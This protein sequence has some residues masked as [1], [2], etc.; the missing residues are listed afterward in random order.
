MFKRVTATDKI[1]KLD[2]RIRAVAGG[3]GASKTISI[4]LVLIDMAQSDKKPTLTS[5]VSQSFPH[6]KRGAIRDF[7][8]ILQEHNY[9][10]DERW[11]KTDFVYTFETGSKI[12]FF[13]ADQSDKVR[14]PRRDRLFINEANNVS[15]E[16]FDQLEIRTNDFIMLDWNPVSEFWFYTD[17][18]NKRND[19]DFITLN[20]KDNETLP[21]AIVDTIERR[22]GMKNWWRVF[23][24]GELGV[25]EGR[26]YQ[27][28]AIV[29]EI[30]H[31]ARLERYGMDFGYTNDPTAIV[32][33][34]YY[35]GGYILDEISYFRGMSNKE[36]ADTFLE[37]PKALI[38]ADSAEPK[39]IDEIKERG[40]NII[41]AEKGKDSVNHGIQFIQQQRISV[42]KNSFNVIK[43]F[44]NYVW[45]A[46]K[47]KNINVPEEGFDHAMDAIR[48]AITS[49]SKGLD[50]TEEIRQL[51]MENQ[52]RRKTILSDTGL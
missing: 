31:E 37:L 43:E 10:K 8:N 33:L 12:E 51:V 1:I 26:I 27:D 29:N 24:L 40:L 17:I 36:I 22:K 15:L 28:W 2:K 3:T 45:I 6:L 48:Y 7:L 39:S 52:E 18:L 9:Y 20:Y 47:G 34:Y 30:P 4:L 14:G 50:D 19:V 41:G 13:S 42:T 21:P 11:N 44:R 32:A 49:M 25:S 38:V 23:G 46:D 5:I 16:T 35:N